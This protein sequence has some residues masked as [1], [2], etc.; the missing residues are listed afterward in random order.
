MK[1]NSV[2]KTFFIK[3][4]SICIAIILVI[5]VV[6]NLFIGD[7]MQ[8]I[9]NLLSLDKSKFRNDVRNKVRNELKNGLEK[10]TIF[11]NED[12]ILIYKLYIKIKDEFKDLEEMK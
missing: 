1:N 8:T 10:E 12:K 9:N 6:F 4:I 3:L 2:L 11:S 5:N 7:K